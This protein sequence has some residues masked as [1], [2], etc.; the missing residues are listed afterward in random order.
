MQLT[1]VQ[2]TVVVAGDAHNPTIL[3]PDFLEKQDIV[4]KAWG[5]TLA[6]T[7]TTP[8]F[9][10]VR[11]VN[12][13]SIVVELGKLQIN[14]PQG[15]DDPLASK[16]AGI[17]S[18]YVNTLQHVR[19]SAVGINF[20]TAVVGVTPAEFVKDRFLKKGPWDRDGHSLQTAGIRLVYRYPSGARLTLSIDTG[21]K[22]DETDPEKRAVLIV[23][24]NFHRA[25]TEDSTIRNV[26]DCLESVSGDWGLYQEILTNALIQ[27]VV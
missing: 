25:C 15:G 19:Y 18:A 5:W 21:E 7:L 3:N 2:H 8:P 17:A 22:Q 23:R 9:A 20:Q 10:L 24:A 11:Y 27:E 16:A 12:G 14:D 6:E 1:L 4:P 13:V 26:I